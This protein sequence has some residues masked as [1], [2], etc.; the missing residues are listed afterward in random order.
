MAE[1]KLVAL[2]GYAAPNDIAKARAAGFDA[3]VSKPPKLEALERALEL[4]ADRGTPT[5]S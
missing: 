1:T 5:R 3:H 4:E 2:I